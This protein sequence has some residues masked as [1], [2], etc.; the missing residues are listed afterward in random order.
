MKKTIQFTLSTICTVGILVGSGFIYTPSIIFDPEIWVVMLAIIVM[1]LT[2]PHINKADLLNPTDKY[3]MLGIFL[4]AII[5]HNLAVMEWAMKTK[6]YFSLSFLKILGFIMIW[7][8]IIF[9]IYAIKKL[10]IYFSNAAEIQ[11]E[12][13]LYDEGIYAKVR[14]PS[15]SGAISTIIG[16]LIWLE[17]WSV[18]FICLLLI[19]MAYWHRITQ[20]EK[21]LTNHF[22]EKYIQYCQK[23]GCLLPKIKIGITPKKPVFKNNLLKK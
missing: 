13:Q 12:H 2:Q 18:F 21:L 15:Y 3:S 19:T 6:Y 23:T 11:K 9:R 17:S 7:G 4:M 8:G 16:T 10:S 1:L 14:H 5:V 22:K 20:E